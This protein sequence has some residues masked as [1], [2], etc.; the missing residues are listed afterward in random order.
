MS[1]EQWTVVAMKSLISFTACGSKYYL[2]VH[3]EHS[4]WPSE[5]QIN[6]FNLKLK[7]ASF[8]TPLDW[9]GTRPSSCFIRTPHAVIYCCSAS[10][11]LS[12]QG[13]V[14]KCHSSVALGRVECWEENVR[15]ISENIEFFLYMHVM[16][17]IA[18]TYVNI[19]TSPAFP[20]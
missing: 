14:W 4:W 16:D 6:R 1:E 8:T 18:F 12:E 15:K 5:K 10:Q 2:H 9:K 13:N 17:E 11:T 20:G 3:Y 19:I 7:S